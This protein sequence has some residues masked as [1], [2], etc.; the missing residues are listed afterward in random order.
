[1]SIDFFVRAPK[2][3]ATD[4]KTLAAALVEE[5]PGLTPNGVKGTSF[6]F[7]GMEVDL[8]F[9]GRP[10]ELVLCNRVCCHMHSSQSEAEQE[11]SMRFMKQV[12]TSLG[13][14]LKG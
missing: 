14:A 4:R 6:W 12:S 1:M 10:E 9:Q 13:W 2:G 11:K 8:D 5:F 3:E 7:E